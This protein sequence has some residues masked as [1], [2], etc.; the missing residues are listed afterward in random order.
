MRKLK[1]FFSCTEN[2][3]TLAGRI[4][5]K[6]QGQLQTIVAPNT[7]FSSSMKLEEI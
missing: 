3:D 4:E 1:N 6:P 5:T 2:T 7:N